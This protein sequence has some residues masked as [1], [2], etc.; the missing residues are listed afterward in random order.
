MQFND[1]A[2]FGI[3]G[4][5]AVRFLVIGT[6]AFGLAMLS[7]KSVEDPILKLKRYF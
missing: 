1:V 2:H 4:A 5:V 7:K 3:P 6:A